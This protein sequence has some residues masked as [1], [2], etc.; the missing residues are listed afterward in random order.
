MRLTAHFTLEELTAS[1]KAKQLHIDNT[2][3]PEHI[4]NLQE[5]ADKI[6]EPLRVAWGSPII[7][8]SG[9][10]GYKLNQAVKGSTTSAHC[11]GLAADLVPY[12]GDIRGF[13][14]FVRNFLHRSNIAYDQYIDEKDTKGSE[15]VHVGIRNRQGKQRHQ[16]L[17]TLDAKHYNP[18]PK[19]IG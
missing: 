5:L 16:D 10:R 19:W 4:A 7:V 14:A 3:S 8:S 9:Y 13:K 18:L 17:F 11:Y 2:P 1:T 12:N 15:W 6:L